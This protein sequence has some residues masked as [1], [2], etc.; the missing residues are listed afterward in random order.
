MWSKT[1]VS[2]EIEQHWRQWNAALDRQAAHMLE[3][4]RECAVLNGVSIRDTK[5]V[6]QQDPG[7]WTKVHIIAR[8]R[9]AADA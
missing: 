9:V 2:P 6:L 8:V 4:R 3:L 1:P 5:I 7:D